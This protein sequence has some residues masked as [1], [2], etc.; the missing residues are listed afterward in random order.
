MRRK[1]CDGCVVI[2]NELHA[3]VWPVHEAVE[4]G[5]PTDY[6]SRCPLELT[7]QAKYVEPQSSWSSVLLLDE[8]LRPKPKHVAEGSD[9]S[10]SLTFQAG[11]ARRV[12]EPHPARFDFVD[13]ADDFH[14]PLRRAR[15]AFR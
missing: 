14:A 9:V 10:F 13:S 1:Q 12:Q 8:S 15:L 4:K 11:R 3:G 6:I 2:H 5:S 7:V